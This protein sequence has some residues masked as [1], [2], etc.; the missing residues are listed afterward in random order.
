MLEFLS[1]GF[2][3]LLVFVDKINPI[4]IYLILFGMAFVENIFPPLPG[5][6]FTIIGGYLAA[7][8]KLNLAMTLGSVT[9]GTIL[10]VM[11]I[12]SLGYRHGREYFVRKRFRI[13]NAYDI[14]RVKGW[15]YRF[16]VWTLLFSRF[17]VGGRVAIAIGAGISKYPPIRMT[18]Y[19]FISA[20]L[21][22]GTLIV[23]A[24][25]THAYV[26]DLIRGFDL[27]SKIILII[28]TILIIFWVVILV[29]RYKH[30]KKKT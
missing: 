11:L 3:D 29:R 24:Y 18:I 28:L 17:V 8:G 13:F 22:H 16:G 10:S 15:F 20:V 6:T 27:Y 5:D 23:L 30:G 9:L 14:R 4:Y 12:Y 7:A 21:F 2:N 26:D 19:S 25:L 1:S